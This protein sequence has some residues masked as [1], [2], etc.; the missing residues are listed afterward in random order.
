L[1][2]A[3]GY[4]QQVP[5]F[6]QQKLFTS[7]TQSAVQV[8]VPVE[9]QQVGSC[10]HT[11]ATQGSEQLPLVHSAAPTVQTLWHARG[12]LHVGAVVVVVLVVVV[13][14]GAAVVVVVGG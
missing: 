4:G 9:S 13:V 6:G 14:V 1:D 2:L 3:A 11:T 7:D 5:P 12:G 8:N 10:A